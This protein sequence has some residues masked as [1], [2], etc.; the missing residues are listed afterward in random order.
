MQEVDAKL[1]ILRKIL[2]N[3]DFISIKQEAD[4][5]ANSERTYNDILC[6]R[7]NCI[8]SLLNRLDYSFQLCKNDECE[9]IFSYS[10]IVAEVIN[11]LRTWE[12]IVLD[13][14]A[15]EGFFDEMKQLEE[16]DGK[17]D[18]EKK[19]AVMKNY[20]PSY[21]NIHNMDNEN[22]LSLFFDEDNQESRVYYVN[23]LHNSYLLRLI[24]DKI[25]DDKYIAYLD[26]PM[27]LYPYNAASTYDESNSTLCWLTGWDEFYDNSP[28]E[29]MYLN[30]RFIFT[31][32]YID[33]CCS[34]HYLKPMKDYLD[35]KEYRYF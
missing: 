26:E 10:S 2:D 32:I 20:V 12:Y 7:L 23:I 11:S 13:E 34:K 5:V 14:Y 22:I 27:L 19:I 29:N 16:Q 9:Y 18:S 8:I 35:T 21:L 25:I 4:M 17:I 3:N 1:K 30:W 6:T 15:Y 24:K 33:I 31:L 28:L